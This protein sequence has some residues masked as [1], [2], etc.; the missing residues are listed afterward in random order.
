MGCL[1]NIKFS[2]DRNPAV[3]NTVNPPLI[4]LYEERD[5]LVT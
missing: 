5:V 4:R 2:M 1:Q 3:I